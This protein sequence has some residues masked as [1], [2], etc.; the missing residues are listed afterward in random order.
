MRGV[1]ETIKYFDD[2]WEKGWEDK[3]IIGWSYEQRRLLSTI[4]EFLNIKENDLVLEIGC[5][6]GDLT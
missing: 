1:K 2:S 6:R 4:F 5:G 3:V